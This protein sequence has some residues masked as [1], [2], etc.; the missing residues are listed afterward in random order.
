MKPHPTIAAEILLS[1]L[2]TLHLDLAIKRHREP[3]DPMSKILEAAR[4][5]AERKKQ[6]DDRAQAIIEGM[7]ALE[8]KANQAFERPEGVMASTEQEFKDLHKVF[9]EA[10]AIANSEKNG[11]DQT[12]TVASQASSNSSSTILP[13]AGPQVS[14]PPRPPQLTAH[15]PEP[16]ITT[17][18]PGLQGAPFARQ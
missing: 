9:D 18:R 8:T 1:Q 5:V 7:P 6:W 12:K 3:D 11:G 13:I 16:P 2:L 4:L 14:E 17:A 15:H 10:N